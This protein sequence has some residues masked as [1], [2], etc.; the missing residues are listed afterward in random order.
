MPKILIVGGGIRQVQLLEAAKKLDYFVVLCDM[1]TECP[2]YQLADR[3]YAAS[4]LDYE[5]LLEVAVKESVDG[6]ITNSEP[7][8]PVVT[9]L[10]NELGLVGNP[11]DAIDI[12]M[13]KSRFRD[14][15]QQIGV[16]CPAHFAA[17]SFPE[18]IQR[19]PE[20]TFP[21]IIKPCESSGSRGVRK[22]DGFEECVLEEAFANCKKYS[23][24][25][26]V[27]VEEFVE[28][29]SLTTI[30]GDLFLCNGEILWDGLF[31]TTRASWA[32]MVPMTYTAPLFLDEGRTEKLK[33]TLSRLFQSAGAQF[34]EYNVEGYFNKEG[35]F[36]VIEMNVRQG[37]HEIPL[38]I[39]DYSGVD[40]CKLLVSTAVG[41]TTYWDS[42]KSFQRAYQYAIKQTT[43]SPQSGQ[44]D[45]LY[46]D[47]SITKY[48]ARS[49][50]CL[51]EED[52]VEQ[53][54]DGTSMAAIVDLFFPSFEEQLSVYER[55]NDLI[56]IKVK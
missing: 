51:K 37:G 15:Q 34:G 24:N 7:A 33:D 13:S 12:L 16:F 55:M 54:V 26:M 8:M 44:Y 9:R 43:F 25:G 42:L 36:F 48:V 14:L 50:E 47:D 2:G 19:L 46:I 18:V 49:L 11:V 52:Q 29:P 39:K 20:L 32:P 38:L 28:M 27:V 22:I 23:R 56:R 53:C 1:T 3:F 31:F 40:L 4:T 35:D 17:S 5:A 6:I 45:G 21:I 30:E 10:T 41:D